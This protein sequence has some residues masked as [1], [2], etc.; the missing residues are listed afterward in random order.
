MARAP[1][2]RGSGRV[3]ALLPPVPL[4]KPSGGGANPDGAFGHSGSYDFFARVDLEALVGWR[5]GDLLLHVKGQYDDNLN[6]DVGAL[7][8]PIDDADFD[9]PV[10]V[11]ELW[12]EQALLRR[13]P[14]PARWASS[15]SRRSSTATPSRTARTGSS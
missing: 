9:E 3:A 13:P 4:G 14:A 10:Y 11:D 8:D 2:S 6:A 5:G 1:G 15:S 7:S 12:L